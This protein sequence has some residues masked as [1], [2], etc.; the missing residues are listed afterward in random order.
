MPHSIYTNDL[1]ETTMD[2]NESLTVL[3]GLIRHHLDEERSFEKHFFCL[4]LELFSL[5]RALKLFLEKK[6]ETPV[7]KDEDQKEVLVEKDTLSVMM[8]LLISRKSI[9]DELNE[10][11]SSV[12][13][14]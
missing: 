11:S 9:M 2:I 14:N 12:R 6:F 7:F 4:F 8:S 10:L 13:L 1:I 5:N 3:E